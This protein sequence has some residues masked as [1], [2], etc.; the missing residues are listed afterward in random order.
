MYRF[1]QSV[2]KKVSTILRGGST[3]QN[4]KHVSG[5]AFFLRY[6]HLSIVA[7]DVWL[8]VY[9][10]GRQGREY[11]Y[12]KVTIVADGQRD[13]LLWTDVTLNTSY[14]K[15]HEWTSGWTSPM[16]KCRATGHRKYEFPDLCIIVFFFMLWYVLPPLTM[17]V[18]LVF[19][20]YEQV[21][22][23]QKVCV[24]GPMFIRLF[25]LFCWV[26]SN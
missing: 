15:C 7:D 9:L 3:H 20:R 23:T 13:A 2:K 18:T 24:F 4:K 17:L 21:Y 16:N 22:K 1:I 12:C 19:N 6:V 14:N 10:R 26:L 5:N 8:W 25:F 11:K